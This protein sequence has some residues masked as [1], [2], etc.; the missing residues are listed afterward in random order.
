MAP[1]L[2]LIVHSVLIQNTTDQSE[3][4]ATLPLKRN[5]QSAFHLVLILLSASEY[6]K[7]KAKMGLLHIAQK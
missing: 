4:H 2:L 3:F 6:Y 7:A 1:L 5:K